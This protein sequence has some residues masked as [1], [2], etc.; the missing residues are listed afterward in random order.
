[1]LGFRRKHLIER[2]EATPRALSKQTPVV[3]S[4]QGCLHPCMKAAVFPAVVILN[5]GHDI[6]RHEVTLQ[7][8]RDDTFGRPLARR[9][10]PNCVSDRQVCAV[11]IATKE[12][13]A[14]TVL[15]LIPQT[16]KE[17]QG[18]DISAVRFLVPQLE[19]VDLVSLQVIADALKR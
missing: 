4:V 1:M 18:G 13:A 2:P 11:Q 5:S 17:G 14:L 10:Q 16:S 9:H 12:V 8:S 19:A 3:L 7:E 6:P 15:P